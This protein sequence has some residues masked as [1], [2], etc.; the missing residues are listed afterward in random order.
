MDTGFTSRRPM[1]W[2]PKTTYINRRRQSSGQTEP[3]EQGKSR[4]QNGKNNNEQTKKRVLIPSTFPLKK[5]TKCENLKAQVERKVEQQVQRKVE[6]KVERNAS[7]LFHHPPTVFRVEIQEIGGRSLQDEQQIR[8]RMNDDV[9]RNRT[10]FDASIYRFTVLEW[11]R[12]INQQNS[13]VKQMKAHT[14]ECVL[15][16]CQKCDN[17]MKS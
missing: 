2:V 9:T 10:I 4:K 8:Q 11:L 13:M 16:E 3:R 5:S 7:L 15:A 6:W 12:Q 17:F 1:L 14:N